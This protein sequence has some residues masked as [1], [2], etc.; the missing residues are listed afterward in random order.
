MDWAEFSRTVI[1]LCRRMR[2]SQTLSLTKGV[3]G[4]FTQCRGVMPAG[5][6]F[7]KL[8][9]V[10]FVDAVQLPLE[11]T[12]VQTASVPKPL[13]R[14]RTN[15]LPLRFWNRPTPCVPTYRTSAT[16]FL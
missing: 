6:R 10:T 16:L 12:A 13:T 5:N 3:E 7:A 2:P 15:G 14:L 8:R 9:N 1:E 11:S 4:S